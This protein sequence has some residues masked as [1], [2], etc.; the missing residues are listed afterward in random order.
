MAKAYI[1]RREIQDNGPM[2]SLMGYVK[3]TTPHA[4]ET[5]YHGEF[6]A[7]QMDCGQY[8]ADTMTVYDPV[9]TIT[10]ETYQGADGTTET[11]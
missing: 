7:R 10:Q 11:F 4:G 1:V 8:D 9:G 5:I 2:G 6:R 3:T